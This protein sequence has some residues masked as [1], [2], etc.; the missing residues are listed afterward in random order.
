MATGTLG[1]SVTSF[2]IA[3]CPREDNRTMTLEKECREL[4]WNKLKGLKKEDFKA[5]KF[6]MHL[7]QSKEETA[8]LEDVIR[9]LEKRH[10]QQAVVEAI[11]IL[12]KIGEYDLAE[13][14]RRDFYRLRAS[15]PGSKTFN[16][17]PKRETF[18]LQRQSSAIFSVSDEQIADYKWKFQ[19]NLQYKYV[20]A[21]EGNTQRRHQQLMD[22]VYMDLNITYGVPASPNPQHEAL[23]MEMCTA[24]DKSIEPRNIFKSS[25]GKMEPV[26]TLLTVGI[27]GIGKTFLVHKFVMDWANRKTNTDVQFIF[28]FTFRELNLEKGKKFSLAELVRLSIYETKPLSLEMLNI[29]FMRLQLSGKRDYESA[30]IKIVFVLDGLDECRLKLEAFMKEKKKK[31]QVDLDVTK[32]YP[33]E[34]LLAHLIKK[35]LLPC[36]RVWITTR[37]ATARQIPEHLI[38]ST[39]EVKGFND[40]QKLEYFR[41]KFP[42]KEDIV[43][44]IQNSHTIFVMCNMPI[45]CWLTTTVLQNYLDTG[46]R[47]ELPETLTEMYTEFMLYHL[48]KAKKRN[49]KKAIQDVQ[50][51]AKLAFHHLMKNSQIF[52]EN[53][54]QDSGFN[55]HKVAKNC[56]MFTE[57]FK[58]VRPLY[59]NQQGKIFEFI[60]QSM[61]E[62]LAALYVMMSLLNDNRNILAESQLSVEGILT[63]CKQI[64]ITKLHEIAIHK[65]SRSKGLLDL[66]LRFLLGLSLQ[67]NQN[68]LKDLLRVS[69]GSWESN[70]DT[71]QLIKKQ[72][73][74][75]FPE[76]NIN[77]FY[78]LNELKDGSLLEQIQQ[79]LKSGSLSTDDLPRSMW[80]ALVFFL[81]SSD[82]ALKC[83]ELKRYSASLIGLYMLLPV[84]KASQKS[85][86]NNCNLTKSSCQ[87][88]ASVLSSHSNL[89]ELDLGDNDLHDA[90]IELLS[91]GLKTP[92]CT[93]Q[94]LRLSG[95]IITVV[96][97]LSLAKALKLNP[98]H[99]RVLDLRY[100]HPGE[101][102]RTALMETQMHPS[103]CL[104]IVKLE[105]G[106]IDRLITGI[107]KYICRPTLDPNTAHRNL[108]LS[109]HCRKVTVV[110][111][112]QPYP[113]NPQRFDSWRQVLC[114]ARLEGRCYWEMDWQG[115]VYIAVTY[116]GLRRIGEGEDICL[117]ATEISWALLCDDDGSYAVRHK[118]KTVYLEQ[119]SFPTSKKV[120]V[121]LDVSAG[122]LSFYKVKSGERILLHTY[123]HTF[124]QSLYPAFGFGFENGYL[125]YGSSLAIGGDSLL[126][127]F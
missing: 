6:H 97:C 64:P 60:H 56:G 78:C 25:S 90:G 8:E 59:K 43:S 79:Y 112:V 30:P 3:Y 55:V 44:Y 24:M 31:R 113:T 126:T 14:L 7:P 105:H 108:S 82:Q 5:F 22:D 48:D 46:K 110:K 115:Q 65:A 84:V 101:E 116:A 18:R 74:Q 124:T 61:Q 42:N 32:A 89:R 27:A 13:K 122:E 119:D 75:N 29:I 109:D 121:F 88:L 117:G 47:G 1:P 12:E 23:Y 87:L 69:E 107:K 19:D 63:L 73:E 20:K 33:V 26:R 103:S 21:Q 123:Q 71:I 91:A 28:P 99:L 54:L 34:V 40:Y 66:F 68:L 53:D 16:L 49:A 57:V 93:L 4:L 67:S 76:D 36:A 17:P 85:L 45:F 50:A 37:P 15:A 95:C 120:A 11:T 77:L 96:G 118:G 62:Y 39:T 86:L 98:T 127:R 35:N 81:R 104:K 102:G 114:G 92:Q 72:I 111:E 125:G 10:G 83:F 9:E 80:A 2:H 38:D 51:L 94:I 100:N 41:G 106:S 52:Y 70:E 58:E